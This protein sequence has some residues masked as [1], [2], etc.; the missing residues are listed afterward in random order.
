MLT[1]CWGAVNGA[2]PHKATEEEPFDP[3]P[4]VCDSLPDPMVYPVVVVGDP[5][6]A[7]GADLAQVFT[8]PRHPRL[9]PL[10]GFAPSETEA[11]A[12]CP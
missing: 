3:I 4:F 12:V 6:V 5:D 9:D 11:I 8:V 1:V 7:F 10:P 2:P